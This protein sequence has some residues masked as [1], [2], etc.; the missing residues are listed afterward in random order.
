MQ[1]GSAYVNLIGMAKSRQLPSSAW[2]IDAIEG[3]GAASGDLLEP[4]HR[5]RTQSRQM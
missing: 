4:M 2:A 3:V 5:I 1:T